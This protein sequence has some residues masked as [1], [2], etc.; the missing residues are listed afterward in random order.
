MVET[1]PVCRYVMLVYRCFWISNSTEVCFILVP[2]SSFI[3]FLWVGS[4][5]VVPACRRFYWIAS[6]LSPLQLILLSVSIPP[7]PLIQP[8][9]MPRL[10]F[11]SWIPPQLCCHHQQNIPAGFNICLCTDP[12]AHRPITKKTQH[13][14]TTTRQDEGKAWMKKGKE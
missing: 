1:P 8:A 10:A 13:K 11:L 2:N 3:Y 6:L 9:Y 4:T 12:T 7:F 14:V 5:Y